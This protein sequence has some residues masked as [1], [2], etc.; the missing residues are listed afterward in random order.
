MILDKF[1]TIEELN[2]RKKL[3]N[4]MRSTLNLFN[5]Q[6][7]PLKQEILNLIESEND[8]SKLQ[9]VKDVLTKKSLAAEI[10]ENGDKKTSEI[11]GFL[12][13]KLTDFKS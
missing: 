10:L 3:S 8:E 7:S 11:L 5:T 6:R 1:K 13:N 9:K 12:N 4:A 2:E